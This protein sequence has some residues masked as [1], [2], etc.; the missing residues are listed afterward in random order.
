MLYHQAYSRAFFGNFGIAFK[1]IRVVFK[2]FFNWQKPFTL[3]RVFKYLFYSIVKLLMGR[4]SKMIYS[5]T[6]ED[7]IIESLLKISIRNSGYYVDVGC[8][9]PIF[10]S[11]TFS[12]Y[13]KGWRGICIDA[14]KSLVN[15]YSYLRPRDKA[16]HALVS[17]Q[18]KQLEFLQYTNDVLSSVDPSLE[19]EY[20][21]IGQNVEKRVKTETQTLTSILDEY[22]APKEFDFLSVDAE[23][24]DFQVLNSL[25]FDKYNPKLIVVEMDDFDFTSPNS[26]PIYRLLVTNKYRLNGYIL[27]NAYFLHH[28]L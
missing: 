25:D 14:N 2:Q 12:F 7:Q 17:D 10:I 9:H 8:N 18:D 24:H 11:N 5:H 26:H 13:R 3:F 1:E 19:K 20:L 4:S 21:N 6:G 22:S 28:G 27:K 16:V 15:K 23:E